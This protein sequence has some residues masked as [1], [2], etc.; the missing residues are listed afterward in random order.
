MGRWWE[1]IIK[2]GSFGWLLMML[3]VLLIYLAFFTAWWLRYELELGGKVLAPFYSPFGQFLP[4]LL[5]LTVL[6]IVNLNFEQLYHNRRGTT[7][8]DQLYG[9]INATTTSVLLVI[10]FFFIFQYSGSSRLVYTYLCITLVSYLS[11]ARLFLQWWMNWLRGKGIGVTC[12]LIVGGGEIGRTLMSHI[13]AQPELGYDVVGFVDDNPDLQHNIGRFPVLGDTNDIPRLVREHGLEKVIITLPWHYQDNILR[14]MELCEQEGVQCRIVP[15][16][17]HLSL[18]KVTLDEIKGVPLIGTKEPALKGIN[19]AL[20]RLVDVTISA[21]VLVL[22]M[23]ILALVVIAIKLESQGQAIF[24]QTRVGRNGR[25]FEVYKFRSMYVGADKELQQL[26]QSNEADGPLFKIRHD[27][28]VTRVGRFIRKT[29]LD[30]FPQLWNVLMG[31]MS[32]VGPRPSLPNEVAQYEDWHRKR[33]EAPPGLTGLWQVSGRSDIPFDD[34]MLLDI[35][36]TEQWSLK[37][38]IIILLKTIPAVLL[39]RGAY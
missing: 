30:E 36:Y 5:L 29:S 34:M 12:T 39:Q 14:I 7:W 4:A 11:S 6:M 26:A 35:Y 10:V 22:V 21:I 3:D 19:Y 25:L 31:D 8:F 17:F 28:R 24:K 37:L 32:L 20:K 16:L 33:L 1:Q 2:R 38:D 27:P 9:I 18:T 13:V 15:D 23:P